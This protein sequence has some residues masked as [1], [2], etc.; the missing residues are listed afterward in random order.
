MGFCKRVEFDQSKVKKRRIEFLFTDYSFEK[1]EDEKKGWVC[2]LL[3][4]LL[5]KRVRHKYAHMVAC[6]GLMLV[7]PNNTPT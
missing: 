6:A 4:L 7:C 5:K 3:F 2:G 1:G